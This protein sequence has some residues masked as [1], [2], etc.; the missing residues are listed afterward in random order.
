[1]SDIPREHPHKATIEDVCQTTLRQLGSG[2]FITIKTAR[3]GHKEWS[4]GVGHRRPGKPPQQR[5]LGLPRVAQNADGLQSILSSA[6]A[7][8]KDEPVLTFGMVPSQQLGQ[9][10]V[11]SFIDLVGQFDGRVHPDGW[12]TLADEKRWPDFL[13]RAEEMGVSLAA[14]VR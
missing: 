11:S 7:E 10:T 8:I 13:K 5:N 9:E 12:I 2:W 4:L 14:S 6:V 1:M 3:P